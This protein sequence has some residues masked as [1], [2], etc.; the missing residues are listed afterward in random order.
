M[1]YRARSTSGCTRSSGVICSS[2]SCA[3]S[4]ALIVLCVDLGL[5][6]WIAWEFVGAL[7]VAIGCL[8]DGL[9]YS[10]MKIQPTIRTTGQLLGRGRQ[11]GSVH[12]SNASENLRD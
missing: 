8:G 1:S 5:W 2:S 12:H 4:G 11:S 6:F 10:T 9:G 3:S 7:A